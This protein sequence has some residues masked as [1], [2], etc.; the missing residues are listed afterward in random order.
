MPGRG[1]DR[2]PK[3][4]VTQAKETTLGGKAACSPESS[5]PLHVTGLEMRVTAASMFLQNS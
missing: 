4:H 5:D 2:V 3:E 1:E